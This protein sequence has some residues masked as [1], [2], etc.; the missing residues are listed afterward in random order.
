MS[1]TRFAALAVVPFFLLAACET[2]DTNDFTFDD[3]TVGQDTP[4]TTDRDYEMGDEETVNLSEIG[5]SGV[6][7]E[8]TFTA[9]NG[10]TQVMVEVDDAPPNTALTAALHQGDDCDNP[11]MEVESLEEFTTDANGMGMS[12]SSVGM[13]MDQVLG[14]GQQQ[15][16]QHLVAVS[17]QNNVVACGEVSGGIF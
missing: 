11:G 10:E 14:E 9:M 7:G 3:D 5:D 4:T 2:D 6:S 12:Q 16:Q 15:Q 13:R 1:T 8:A 17:M